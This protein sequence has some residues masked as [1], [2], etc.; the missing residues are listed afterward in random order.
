MVRD[1]DKGKGLAGGKNKWRFY[2]GLAIYVR[3]RCGSFQNGDSS[4]RGSLS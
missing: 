4:G 1:E 3:T 2:P